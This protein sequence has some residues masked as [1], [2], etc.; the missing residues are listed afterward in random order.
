MAVQPIFE[1]EVVRKGNGLDL[2]H[3]LRGQFLAHSPDGEGFSKAFQ[4]SM[5]SKFVKLK[6]C[7]SLVNIEVY[8]L[9]HVFPELFSIG[10]EV[11]ALP[12]SVKAANLGKC[13]QENYSQTRMN[14]A[15]ILY[16]DQQKQDT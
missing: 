14:H 13:K 8:E 2:F 5:S 11:M 12:K 4:E 15:Q 10:L 9:H 16:H 6:T 7:L 1:H 3:M